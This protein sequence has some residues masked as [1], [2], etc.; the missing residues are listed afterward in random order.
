MASR[1]TDPEC[2]FTLVELVVCV[3]LF[4][5]V[6]AATVG[7]VAVVLRNAMPNGTRDVAMMV[8]ENT[9]ARARAAAAYVPIGTSSNTAPFDPAA[10]NLVSSQPQ[11]FTAGAELRSNNVCNGG[12]TSLRLLL[13][14][15]TTY[16]NSVLTVTVTYPRDPC[17]VAA[18]GTIPSDD[19]L[20]IT[21][22]ETLS[23]PLYIPGHVLVRPIGVPAKM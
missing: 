15:Q 1:T 12:T 10:A 4:A 11:A 3:A 7:G 6:S 19:A 9:L 16:A 23:P 8:L 17:R 2:G 21:Q 13:P 14:V 20:T 18:D 22:S 5:I